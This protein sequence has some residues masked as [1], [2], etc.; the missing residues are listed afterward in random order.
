[1][2]RKLEDKVAIV[3][4]AA[5]GVGRCIALLMAQQGAKVVIADNGSQVDGGGRDNEPAE[6]VAEEINSAGGTA[7][8]VACDVSD[9][10]EARAMVDV[11][12]N[13]WGKLDILANVAGNF[14]TNTIVS[15]TRDEWDALRRVHIDGMMHTSHFA[16]LHWKDRGEY[17]RLINFTSDSAMSGVP[18]TFAY[19]A[20]KGSIMS[21]TRAIANAMIS[22]KVTANCIT[23]SSITRMVASYYQNSGEEFPLGEEVPLE[24]RPDTVAPLIVYLASEAAAG[25]SGRIFG[26]YGYKYIRWSEPH[27]ECVL[28][29]K[30]NGPWDLDH[31]FEH[32]EETLAKG[33]DLKKDLLWA[34]DSLEEQQAVFVPK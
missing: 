14:C 23:Q 20:V 19:A 21:M 25:I 12:I 18:D 6:I 24:L 8:A 30:D 13:K 11:P 1:M 33:L 5:R 10:D 29:S 4:G 32:F 31:V 16:C 17:G 22:Y 7:I 15:V 34:M 27:H 3:T 2:E 26:S 9:W 28:E